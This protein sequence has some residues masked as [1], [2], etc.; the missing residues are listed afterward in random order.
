MA[1]SNVLQDAFPSPP[2]EGVVA[3]QQYTPLYP[4]LPNAETFRLGEISKIEKQISD[5]SE[6]YRLVLKKY[7]KAQKATSYVVA[8]LGVATTAVLRCCRLS[9]DRSR[10]NC[11]CFSRYCQWVVWHS[12]HRFDRC[13]QKT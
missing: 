13:Q 7:K 8:S 2:S 6:H 1:A 12:F 3:E 11:Q 10:N 5:E 4:K 9:D